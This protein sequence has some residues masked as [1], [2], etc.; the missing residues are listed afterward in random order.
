MSAVIPGDGIFEDL[1]IDRPRKREE[2]FE[3][4]REGHALQEALA[5]SSNHGPEPQILDLGRECPRDVERRLVSGTQHAEP[6]SDHSPYGARTRITQ[7]VT[8]H[9][10]PDSLLLASRRDQTREE[11]EGIGWRVW[12]TGRGKHS[13]HATNPEPQPRATA[14]FDCSCARREAAP[15]CKRAASSSERRLGV[16]HAH[17]IA[18]AGVLG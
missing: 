14:G 12:R 7:R 6:R 1:G 11:A 2:E 15:S 8:A 5:C 3:L 13:K 10:P 18:E 17:T 4:K 16:A 9:S